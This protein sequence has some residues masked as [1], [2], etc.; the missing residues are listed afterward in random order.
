M[1]DWKND[2]PTRRQL[3]NVAQAPDVRGDAVTSLVGRLDGRLA[4]G[5]SS[6]TK[7]VLRYVPHR[8]I[9]TP[10]S[11][12]DYLAALGGVSWS[13]LEEAAVVVLGDVNDQVVP[14]WLRVRLLQLGDDQ[15]SRHDVVVEDRQPNWDNP[16]LLSRLPPLDD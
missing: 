16:G 15:V 5:G 10:E 13:S 4:A 3:L 1:T 12:T 9:L 6:E 14:R 7:V 2:I 11:L 8:D